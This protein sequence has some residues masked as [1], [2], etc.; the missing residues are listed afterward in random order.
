MVNSVTHIP[1]LPEG[2][3]GLVAAAVIVQPVVS[4][5]TSDVKSSAQPSH[6]FS[7]LVQ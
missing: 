7:R 6:I 5:Q 2:L 1:V 3:T 4:G